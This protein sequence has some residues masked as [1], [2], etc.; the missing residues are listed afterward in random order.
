MGAAFYCSRLFSVT[1][2]ALTTPDGFME[3]IPLRAACVASHRLNSE[4]LLC[5]YLVYPE[6]LHTEHFQAV[7]HKSGRNRPLLTGINAPVVVWQALCRS[8]MICSRPQANVR[9]KFA[10]DAN[11]YRSLAWRQ[12]PHKPPQSINQRSGVQAFAQKRALA[13]AGLRTVRLRM[14]TVVRLI[15]N[16]TM[17]SCRTHAYMCRCIVFVT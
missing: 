16:S 17:A 6:N 7:L 10:S 9:S 4:Y 13:P 5:G 3:G 14:E 11:R 2:G 12:M 8:V 15:C 1:S